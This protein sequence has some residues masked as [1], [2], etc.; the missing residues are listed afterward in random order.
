MLHLLKIE[1]LKIRHYRAFWVLFSLFVIAVL[2]INYIA[3]YIK[4]QIERDGGK[5]IGSLVGGPFS[6]PEVWQTVGWMTSWLLYFPGFIIIFLVTNEYTFRT[7]RQNI[8]DG[9]SR[10]QFVWVKLWVAT[11]LAI[12]STVMM[13]LACLLF[14][15]LSEGGSFEFEELKYIGYFF[16]MSMV[17]ML[18]ALTLALLLR[19]AALAVGIFFIFGLIFD[20]VL[21]NVVNQQMDSKLGTYLMPIDVADQLIPFPFLKSVSK[22]VMKQA[23]EWICLGIC[24][25][26]IVFYHWFALRKFNTED[27]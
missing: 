21:A 2:G 10:H 17:Y 4:T 13:I 27:L 20:N 22:S 12:I 6:F 18:F 5:M 1:W 7:H 26:W 14:G 11:M 24:M 15:L 25:G 19:R 9:L 8:I 3:W 23:N 16:V